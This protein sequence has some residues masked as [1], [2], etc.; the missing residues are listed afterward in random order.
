VLHAGIHKTGTTTL[1]V[2]LESLRKPLRAHGVAL[3]TIGQMKKLE[4]DSAWG[5]YRAQGHPDKDLFVEEFR[6]LVH[7]EIEAV[8]RKTAAPVQQVLITS[9]RMVGARM[10]STVDHP[11][12]RPLAEAAIG[13]IIAALDPEEVHLALY[14]R[15]QDRLMES[16]YLWEV[17]KG[18]SHTIHTQFPFIDKPVLRF[19]ELAERLLSIPRIDTIRVRPFEIISGGSLAYLD[20]FLS[21]VGL[22]GRLDYSGFKS[23]PSSNRSYSQRALDIA[24]TINPHLETGKQRTAARQFLKQQFPV[25]DYPSAK[26]LTDEE[27]ER[28]VAVYRDDNERLFSTWMPELPYDSY[29]T[30]DGS[31]RLRGVLAPMSAG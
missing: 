20:D 31:D 19:F 28:V 24:L 4:H 7:G 29:S 10:P 17:Q 9:E 16:C 30:V 15:R 8:E 18:L 11:K 1:Q 14:T 22:D 23:E 5:A 25:G 26:I 6:A 2:A 12:F 27:R 13:E 21:N 3:I